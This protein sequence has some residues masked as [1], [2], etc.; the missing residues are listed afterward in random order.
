MA[1]QLAVRSVVNTAALPQVLND[2]LDKAQCKLSERFARLVALKAPTHQLEP[3]QEL[4]RRELTELCP[5]TT[6]VENNAGSKIPSE[7]LNAASASESASV[8]IRSSSPAS[9]TPHS[10]PSSITDESRNSG[11]SCMTTIASTSTTEGQEVLELE[12]G[13]FVAPKL[14]IPCDDVEKWNTI[15]PRLED[16]LL[17]LFKPK[18][19]LDPSLSLELVMAGPFKAPLKPSIVLTCCNEPHRKRLKKLLK[20]QKWLASTGYP[21]AVVVDPIQQLSLVQRRTE[22]SPYGHNTV[23]LSVGLGVGLGLGILSLMASIAFLLWR[24]RRRF[25]SNTSRRETDESGNRILSWIRGQDSIR[26]GP[27]T[28]ISED[29]PGLEEQYASNARTMQQSNLPGFKLAP[30]AAMAQHTPTSK[31]MHKPPSSVFAQMDSL[32]RVTMCGAPAM[33]YIRGSQHAYFTI[34]GTVLI[35]GSMYGLAAGNS[36]IHPNW[37]KYLPEK[38]PEYTGGNNVG[39]PP[40]DLESDSDSGSESN[41]A[42]PWVC[43]VHERGNGTN[44]PEAHSPQQ[45]GDNVTCIHS[46]LSVSRPSHQQYRP[47]AVDIL[48][49]REMIGIIQA[50]VTSHHDHGQEKVRLDWGLIELIDNRCWTVNK[51]ISDPSSSPEEIT[52]IA[53]TAH[54]LHGEVTVVAGFTGVVKGWLKQD[55]VMLRLGSSTYEAHQIVLGRS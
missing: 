18:P 2:D 41:T 47:Q 30:E 16:A 52:S 24:R 10:K 17:N 40:P 53:E 13:V 12:K 46:S 51:L 33:V 1:E 14:L 15:Q 23:A 45:I 3:V 42:S 7:E 21:L 27:N 50:P 49:E 4:A 48:S 38:V 35:D 54:L 19:G 11:T 9:A 32:E 26:K 36:L 39:S 55:P 25:H 31:S 28:M 44:T 37:G 22:P 43:P 6:V 34:G 8:A 5:S 20:S 29:S